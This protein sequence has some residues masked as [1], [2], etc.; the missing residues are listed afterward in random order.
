MKRKAKKGKRV[1]CSLE[2]MVRP[3]DCNSAFVCMLADAFWLPSTWDVY[4]AESMVRNFKCVMDNINTFKVKQ[5]VVLPLLRVLVPTLRGLLD[6]VAKAQAEAS[7]AGNDKIPSVPDRRPKVG[8]VISDFEASWSSRTNYV[9]PEVLQC[10][11][12]NLCPLCGQGLHRL[13]KTNFTQQTKR[14]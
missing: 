8:D 2:R 3:I 9:R 7:R 1:G 11:L 14:T 13:S 10:L 12:P 6:G 5:A 4:V